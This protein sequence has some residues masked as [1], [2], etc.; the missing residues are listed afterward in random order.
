MDR[1][2]A[3]TIIFEEKSIPKILL[4][5]APP[6]MLAQLIQAL[7]NIVDSFFVGQ[8]SGDGLT[9]LSV[10]FPIQ[11]IVTA[12]AVGTGVG[13][14]TLMS[15]YYAQGQEEKANKAAGT[16]ILLSL[17]SWILFAIASTILMEPYVLVSVKSAKAVEF[18]MTYGTIVCV[19]SFGLF[20][21]SI[22]TKVHQAKGN[23]KL[24]MFA[25][26][27]GAATNIVLDPVLIFGFGFI[28]SMGVAGAAYATIIGQIVAATITASGFKK[29]P[30][31]ADVRHFAKRIY[32]LGYPSIFMQMLYTVYIVILNIILAGFSDAAVTVLG[33]YYKVQSF[34]FI[35]LSGL[36]TCIVPLLSYTYAKGEYQR[37][38]HIMTNSVIMAVSFMLFGV[39]CFEFIPTQ[40]LG[41]FSTEATVLSIGEN[42]FRIIGISFIPAVFSLISP[43]F[44]QAIGSSG[45][46]V[47][48]SLT[49]QIFC[50]IPIF[51]VL[52]FMGLEYTWFA[53]PIAEIV[54]G[55]VGWLLYR[56][57]L[58]QWNFYD[59]KQT[60][61]NKGDIR[62]KLITAI[63]NRKDVGEVCTSLTEAGYY[64]TK[65]MSSGGFL[66]SGNTTLIIGTEKDK[67][68]DVM[69]IIRSHCSKRTEEV[70]TNLQTAT[71]SAAY[72]AQVTVGGATVFV[73]D[74]E[75]FEKM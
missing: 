27:A 72:P 16:G 32:Q 17:V 64:F 12:L 56:R 9:A 30:C 68:K 21:E 40:L 5:I 62:M 47:L 50:L 53:F 36:Q 37:C 24:P 45:L 3:K 23:M 38:K 7:Y 49:R 73:T 67:V 11:L 6:V 60:E 22:W 28:P 20:F 48:L 61:I 1:N 46:S 58:K 59:E 41:I 74:V 39:L 75:E 8:Y 42:A 63:I 31:L 44:F 29:P 43:V 14:N 18:A 69:E 15:R 2:E 33:L 10:I 4:H 13:V 71:P 35:P 55:S 34:F 51:W 66:T 26:I 19:G 52:S 70:A 65:M 25:Q 57:K 54:T